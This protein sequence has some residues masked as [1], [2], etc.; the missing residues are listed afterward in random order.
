MS[1][2]TLTY[3]TPATSHSEQLDVRRQ[4][5]DAAIDIISRE[6]VEHVSMREVARRAG[7]S[8]QAPY[9]YFGDRAGIFA[10]I[11]EEGFHALTAEFRRINTGNI[12]DLVDK[13]FRAYVTF[14]L[15]HT[16]HFRIMFRSDLCGLH[17]HP[18]TATQASNAY[19]EL[20]NTVH[21]LTGYPTDSE[22]A[23]TW[24]SFLWSTAHGFATLITD[25]PLVNKLPD[26][27]TFEN[28]LNHMTQ[29]VASITEEHVARIRTTLPK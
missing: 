28:H 24:A 5:L 25:G 10:S 16:G 6:G 11:A 20:L 1:S 17:T 15:T 14:G 29:L 13:T 23:S 18:N 21:L 7:V 8:H 19:E 27:V 4:V 26:S 12:D 9:H 3:M 2:C 22:D